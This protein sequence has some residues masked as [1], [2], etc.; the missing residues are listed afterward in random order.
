MAEKKRAGHSGDS[1]K[2]A[3]F[4]TALIF[5]LVFFILILC[6]FAAN[7]KQIQTT[8]RNTGVMDRIFGST[9]NPAV[10]PAQD[11]DRHLMLTQQNPAPVIGLPELDD[12]PAAPHQLVPPE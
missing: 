3:R 8:L 12:S 1:G 5:W 10:E 6:L 7:W 2:T 11:L 4:P 9:G